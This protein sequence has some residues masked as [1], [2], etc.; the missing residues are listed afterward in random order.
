M[1]AASPTGGICGL[2]GSLPVMKIPVTKAA[3]KQSKSTV[4]ETLDL[5]N[6]QLAGQLPSSL[7]WLARH[8]SL[9]N[10]NFAGSIPSVMRVDSTLNDTLRD[11]VVRSLGLSGNQLK[12]SQLRAS[13]PN[14]YH[15]HEP[16]TSSGLHQMQTRGP[17]PHPARAKLC[18]ALERTCRWPTSTHQHTNTRAI[19]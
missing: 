13:L 1:G 2:S 6:N 15:I 5:S 12:L 11:A 8:V 14:G 10:N 18:I 17:T 3:W 16:F 4:L 9:Q 19:A 7:V